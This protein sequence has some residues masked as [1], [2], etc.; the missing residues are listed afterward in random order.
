M[1]DLAWER[2]SCATLRR[3]GHVRNSCVECA[4]RAGVGL[5]RLD[6]MSSAELNTWWNSYLETGLNFVARAK[7]VSLRALRQESVHDVMVVVQDY[8]NGWHM[9]AEF[10]RVF[11]PSSFSGKLHTLFFSEVGLQSFL[12]CNFPCSSRFKVKV[13]KVLAFYSWF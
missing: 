12:R 13:L 10:W 8:L 4:Y 1:C 6:M 3:Q 11:V 9:A 7:C 2:I 5:V